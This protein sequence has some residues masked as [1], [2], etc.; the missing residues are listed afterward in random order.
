MAEPDAGSRR[1]ELMLRRPR[2]HLLPGVRPTVVIAGRGQPAQWGLGTWMIPADARVEIGVFL[3][4]RLWRF[5]EAQITVL[6]DHTGVEYRAPWLPY[7]AG[8]V[9]LSTR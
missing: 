4:N 6:S 9:G 1:L 7:G 2:I 8:R 5:G 3:F